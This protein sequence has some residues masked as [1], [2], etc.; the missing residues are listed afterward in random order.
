[1]PGKGLSK[2]L[3]KGPGREKEGAVSNRVLEEGR[4]NQGG[5]RGA[6]EGAQLSTWGAREEGPVDDLEERKIESKEGP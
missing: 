4:E 1:V 2:W 5:P 3:R 6:Q